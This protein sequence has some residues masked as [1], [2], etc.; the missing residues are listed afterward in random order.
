[1]AQWLPTLVGAVAPGQPGRYLPVTL[2]RT[3]LTGAVG[4]S[5]T[6]AL[7]MPADAAVPPPPKPTVAM[8]SAVDVPMNYQGQTLC[9]QN[10]KPGVAAWASIVATNYKRPTYGTIRPCASDVSE[11]YDGRAL[12]WMLNVNNA[13]D[14]AIAD[15]VTT[16][17]TAKDA[18]GNYGAWARRLGIMYIIWNKKTWK[19]Y[20]DINTWTTYT[21]SVR[22]PITFTSALPGTAP[23]SARRGGPVAR[24]PPST[25]RPVRPAPRSR[26]TRSSPSSRTCCS[27][28]ARPAMR[29]GSRRPTCPASPSTASSARRRRRRSRPSRPSTA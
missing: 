2:I 18:N 21:G 7:A 3:T 1:M 11:H 28:S 27:S 17:L 15:A 23:A 12:D 16:W 19:S 13:E 9:S 24:R 29:C 10:T 20:R 4:A 22:T 14:K 6:L 5:L 25:L 8:P 26:S